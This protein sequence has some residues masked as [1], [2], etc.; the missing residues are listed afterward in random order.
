MFL[1]IMTSQIFVKDGPP[2]N[3]LY[4]LL[5]KICDNQNDKYFIIT[6]ISYKKGIFNGVIDDFYKQLFK[7]YKKSKSFYLIRKNNYKK[8]LTI[9]RQLCNYNDIIY[10]NEIK[11]DKSTYELI[12]KV[13]LGK[14]L[15]NVK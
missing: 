11:Y 9:I 12:Y 8:F 15:I 2:I 5:N 7:Y 4:T 3:I 10:T 13:F 1:Y 6:Y 14:C